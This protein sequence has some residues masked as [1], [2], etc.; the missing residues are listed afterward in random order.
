MTGNTQLKLDTTYIHDGRLG[1]HGLTEEQ[2]NE[3][4]PRLRD[5]LAEISNERNAGQH[6]F[7]ELPHERE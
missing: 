3:L 4:S 1:P 2:V 7:R 6:R 5:V